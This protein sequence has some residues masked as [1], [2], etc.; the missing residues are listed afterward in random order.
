MADASPLAADRRDHPV[1]AFTSKSS[2]REAGTAKARDESV[3]RFQAKPEIFPL[4]NAAEE[5]ASALSA[6]SGAS[7]Q[8]PGAKPETRLFRLQYAEA[9]TIARTLST[10]FE[11]P[12]PNPTRILAD[13]RTNTVIVQANE[14]RIEEISKVLTGLDI[15][16]SARPG[17]SAILR[18]FPLKYAQAG[19]LART[20]TT[21]FGGKGDSVKIAGD[22]STNSIIVQADEERIQAI[23][24]VLSR[25]DLPGSDRAG[26]RISTRVIPLKYAKAGE[27]APTLTALF[28]G[29]GDNARIVA[30]ERT[31]A[32]I[33]AADEETDNRIRELIQWFDVRH[34]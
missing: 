16:G 29:K 22:G 11:A 14:E 4:R 23:S 13:M 17:P 28:A 6:R 19:E 27:L 34:R 1:A 21:L 20:L 32:I 31:N 24:S 25:L 30:D 12:A 26:S 10:L 2:N 18:V 33:V 5:L 15:P 8:N 3:P 9:E 7:A